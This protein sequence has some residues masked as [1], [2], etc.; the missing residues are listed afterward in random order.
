MCARAA[1]WC[2]QKYPALVFD[3]LEAGTGLGWSKD[4]THRPSRMAKTGVL[5]GI[6]EKCQLRQNG[7]AVDS[8]Q[9]TASPDPSMLLLNI[10]C[11]MHCAQD[12]IFQSNFSANLIPLI[13]TTVYNMVPYINS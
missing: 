6:A 2:H 13:F 10:T 1:F 5:A 11:V 9:R 3:I 12:T 4:I 8:C 7:F